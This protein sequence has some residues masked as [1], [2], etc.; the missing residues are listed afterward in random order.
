MTLMNT[1]RG[2]GVVPLAGA[3]IASAQQYPTKRMLI[4]VRTTPREEVKKPTEGRH[5]KQH[6][7]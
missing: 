1:L 5:A 3:S 2:I 4:L 7:L 6:V